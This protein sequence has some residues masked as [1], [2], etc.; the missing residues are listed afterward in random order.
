MFFS[1]RDLRN[2]SKTLPAFAY[3]WTLRS[4]NLTKYSSTMEHMGLLSIQIAMYQ[5]IFWQCMTNPPSHIVDSIKFYLNISWFIKKSMVSSCITSIFQGNMINLVSPVYFFLGCWM[6]IK[7]NPP[8]KIDPLPRMVQSYV[9]QK[10]QHLGVS[11][12]ASW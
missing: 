11:L 6:P 10:D 3:A 9:V 8:R 7:K 2:L 4:Q 12:Y 1:F 5:R